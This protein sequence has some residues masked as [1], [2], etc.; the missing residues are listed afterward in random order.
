MIQHG[1]EVEAFR[2]P[3]LF[4]VGTDLVVLQKIG[5]EGN[6]AHL[7]K[8]VA[9]GAFKQLERGECGFFNKPGSTS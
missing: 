1:Q 4:I 2:I 8:L 5:N 9:G 7:L 6:I 3:L